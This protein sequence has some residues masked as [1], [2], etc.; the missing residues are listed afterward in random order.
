M[1]LFFTVCNT[2]TNAVAEYRL[3]KGVDICLTLD[4]YINR[5]QDENERRLGLHLDIGR[6]AI[7]YM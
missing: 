3:E 4:M 5:L 6:I 7:L 2:D 1:S